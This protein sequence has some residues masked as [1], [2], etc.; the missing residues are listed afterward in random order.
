MMTTIN[1]ALKAQILVSNGWSFRQSHRF[2]NHYY[3]YKWSID[4]SVWDAT[5][6]LYFNEFGRLQIADNRMSYP[7]AIEEY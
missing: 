3:W 7:V 1:P 6:Y 5:S 4:R 2:P